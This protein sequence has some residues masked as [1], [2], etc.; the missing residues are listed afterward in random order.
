MTNIIPSARV[1]KGK[2]RFKTSKK[3][4]YWARYYQRLYKNRHKAYRCPFCG[5]YHMS[6]EG[7]KKKLE[8]KTVATISGMEQIAPRKETVFQWLKRVIGIKKTT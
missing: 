8:L 5:D 4:N 2:L 7:G 3:A 1:C 6:S